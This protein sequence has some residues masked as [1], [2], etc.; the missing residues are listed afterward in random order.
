MYA[1]GEGL[2]ADFVQ[3]K[4]GMRWEGITLDTVLTKLSKWKKQKSR[5]V[6][7]G[8]GEPSSGNTSR[9]YQCSKISPSSEKRRRV[10]QVS[11]VGMGAG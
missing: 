4:S 1:W 8:G 3:L 9:Q 2:Y 6:E 11:M 10:Q 7:E 5:P